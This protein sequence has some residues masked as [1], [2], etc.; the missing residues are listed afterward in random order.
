M[1]TLIKQGFANFFAYLQTP[2][3]Q[4]LHTPCTPTGDSN[5]L[6]NKGLLFFFVHLH[7]YHQK[8]YMQKKNKHDRMYIFSAIETFYMGR[9]TINREYIMISTK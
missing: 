6:L 1:Q 9:F 8:I 2:Q 4:K 7:T 3:K 5:P